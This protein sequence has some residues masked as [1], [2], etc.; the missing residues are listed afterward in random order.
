MEPSSI[1]D[2]LKGIVIFQKNHEA[3]GDI[4]E[5]PHQT[6][7]A[8]LQLDNDHYNKEMKNMIIYG[9]TINANEKCI[10]LTKESKISTTNSPREYLD[11]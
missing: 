6:N 8:E 5:N 11:L 7:A 10:P 1:N 9:Y 3:D 4:Y 2:Y